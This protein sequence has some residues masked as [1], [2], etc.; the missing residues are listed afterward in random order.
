MSN[1][2]A[3]VP[4][5][6]RGA[7][8]RDARRLVVEE[9]KEEVGGSFW[10]SAD[11]KTANDFVVQPGGE[12]TRVSV[13]IPE[14]LGPFAKYVPWGLSL[15]Y[16]TT[17]SRYA[18]LGLEICPHTDLSMS[19][20]CY[21]SEPDYEGIRIADVYVKNFSQRAIRLPEDTGFFYLYYFNS[22]PLRGKNLMKMVG[23]DIKIGG[24]EGVDWR[25]WCPKTRDVDKI[26]GIE[27]FI[28]PESKAWI[29]PDN[30]EITIGSGSASNHNRAGV[31]A[32]LES[33]VP[34]VKDPILTIAESKSSLE[35][36]EDVNG[37]VETGVVY[38]GN[39]IGIV[40][41]HAR[42]LD[43]IYMEGGNTYGKF[44]TE[45]LGATTPT[46][47]PQTVAI[48]FFSNRK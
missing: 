25:W 42:H 3:T 35:L 18:Q 21:P 1:P 4:M 33:P 32:Y 48:R 13:V 15:P 34:V 46:L 31:D 19:H 44:R 36:S 6:D 24:E 2:E 14:D 22:P 17:R 28:D 47:S 16:A 9:V 11:V 27:F 29:A 20:S 23:N 10:K 39:R 8:I 38:G 30:T 43:S 45:V 5:I 41:P 7:F 37:L 40:D 26:E 12:R